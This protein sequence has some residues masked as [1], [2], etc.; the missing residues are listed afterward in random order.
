MP[1]WRSL[2][3]TRL[4]SLNL[5]P[6]RER[7]IIDELSQH[8]SIDSRSSERAAS[9]KTRRSVSRWTKSTTKTCWR[10]GCAR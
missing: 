5:R 1:D 7:E 8:L 2:I 6:E 4:A 9:P 10:G 3:A